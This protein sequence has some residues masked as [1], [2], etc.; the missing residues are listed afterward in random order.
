[1]VQSMVQSMGLRMI[2]LNV[3]IVVGSSANDT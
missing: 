3:T 1:M 2:K